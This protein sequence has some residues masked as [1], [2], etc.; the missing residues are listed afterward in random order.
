MN[1][2]IFYLI[3]VIYQI[4]TL[5]LLPFLCIYL[6]IRKIKKKT[7]FGNI[8]HR[9]G[10]IPT[11][12]KNKQIIWFH[13]VS[14][15]EVLSLE[16]VIKQLQSNNSIHCYLTVGTL[17]GY[18]LAIKNIPNIS[19]A[20]LPYDFLPC[21]I[22]AWLRI[23]PYKIIITEAE[24]WPNLIMTLTILKIPC[25]LINARVNIKQG[26]TQW[27]YQHSIA[28]LFKCF[29]TIY[30]QDQ[31]SLN[32]IR[33]YTQQT[34]TL[35][36]G[37]TTKSF[38]VLKKVDHFKA[39]K[40]TLTKNN[41]TVLLV[42]SCHP[43]EFG[44]YLKLYKTLKLSIN[45]LKLLI[46]PRHF[47]WKAD[48]TKACVDHNLSSLIIDDQK[49]YSNLDAHI[50]SHDITSVFL[51]GTLFELYPIATLFFL[52]GTWVPIGGHNILEPIAWQIPSIVG[53]DYHTS[54]ELINTLEAQQGVFIAKNET[55]LESICL[56]L[57]KN[58]ALQEQ[59][60]HNATALL[61]KEAAQTTLIINKL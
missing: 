58:N 24:L 60:A 38:N 3:F 4:A 55:E 44:I 47:S 11:A 22:L 17:T 46:V 2:L 16:Y 43:G 54:T 20:F 59:T 31:Q 41:Y 30:T 57:L 5:L 50:A 7:V 36:L 48:F 49:N 8:A 6:A 25:T 52:G 23:N 53:P 37:G 42:G 21:I 32:F 14:A 51:M 29:K 27:I 39:T 18:Q 15:G 34:T 33:Q 56:T 12:P 40:K 26:L 28:H 19:L 9:F 1:M 61:Q 10:F 45:N 35:E 13:A